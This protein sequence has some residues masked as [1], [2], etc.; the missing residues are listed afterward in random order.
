[1]TD[2]AGSGSRSARVLRS[3]GV[4]AGGAGSRF[5]GQDKAWIGLR[6]HALVEWT[7]DALRPQADEILVSANRNVER[8]A[9]LDVR[10]LRDAQPDAPQGPLAGIVQLMGAATHDWLLCVPCD[11]VHLP[12]DLGTRFA[13]AV[14]AAGADIG[15]LADAQGL[16][17]TFCYLRTALASDAQRCFEGGERAPRRWLARHRIARLEGPTPLNLNTPEALRALEL[18]P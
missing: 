15:V 2:P 17:P 14:D 11:A 18:Q 9:S 3:G 12:P 5:G 7:I 8:Y 10:V 13:A 1:M 4:L 6:G 16:H